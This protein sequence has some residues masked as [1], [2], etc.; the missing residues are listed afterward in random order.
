MQ[1][2]AH[3]TCT[4]RPPSW[5]KHSAKHARRFTTRLSHKCPAIARASHNGAFAGR[6]ALMNLGPFYLGPWC[7]ELTWENS[8]QV[9]LISGRPT[10]PLDH[11]GSWTYVTMR[12]HHLIDPY[13]IRW[14]RACM[15]QEISGKWPK[16]SLPMSTT[17]GCATGGSSSQPGAGKAGAAALLLASSRNARA[18]LYS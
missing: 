17:G 10:S 5:L 11:C 13:Q 15:C 18:A 12:I 6:T 1:H 8:V 3:P 16:Y 2:V 9:A 4:K 14:T 7:E